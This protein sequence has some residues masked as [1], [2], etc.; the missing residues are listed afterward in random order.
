[1]NTQR[2]CSI[3]SSLEFTGKYP[4]FDY[5]T[6]GLNCTLDKEVTIWISNDAGGEPHLFL[7]ERSGFG[8]NCYIGVYQP[9]F[10]GANVLVGAYSYIISANHNYNRRD[11]PIYSQGYVGA[12]IYIEDDVWI[13]T[14]VIVLPGVRIG[15]GAIIAAGS[16]ITKN[17]P[18]YQIWGGAPAHFIK[19]RP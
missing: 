7:G 14:H 3:H 17:V 15:K 4:P 1:M 8:R 18:A 2:G 6:L 5:L 13:G 16:V 9:V 10:I 12:S 19:A 11:I